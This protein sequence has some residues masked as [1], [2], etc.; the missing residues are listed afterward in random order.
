MYYL[1]NYYLNNVDIS[2]NC[3]IGV[4]VKMSHPLAIVIGGTTV[5]GDNC[6]ILSCVTFG[7]N[8]AVGKHNGYPVLGNNCYIG[9][10]AKIIGNITLGDNVVVGANSVV[11]KS[12]PPGIV[13]AGV[14]AKPIKNKR[15]I[16]KK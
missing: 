8:S 10:G 3:D 4:G 16:N 14:P 1:L 12:V 9:T 15:L 2:N 13:V 7:T 5:I 11:T 6:T